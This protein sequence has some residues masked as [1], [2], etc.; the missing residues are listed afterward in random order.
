MF[1]SKPALKAGLSPTV[2]GP[3]A[4]SHASEPNEEGAAQ[5][6]SGLILPGLNLD[7]LIRHRDGHEMFVSHPARPHFYRNATRL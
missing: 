3:G 7:E 6:A 4:P 1:G 2:F 5:A